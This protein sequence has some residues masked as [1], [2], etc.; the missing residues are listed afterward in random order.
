MNCFEKL[1]TEN[2]DENIRNQ[3][4][5][6]IL[7]SYFFINTT[8]VGKSILGRKIDCFH[9][10][11]SKKIILL[12]GGFHGMEWITSQLL[13]KFIIKTGDTII[14]REKPYI[15]NLSECLK[16][17]S[18]AIIPCVNPD[19]VEI[20]INGSHSARHLQNF[21]ERISKGDTSH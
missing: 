3:F 17:Y 2:C 9:I 11:N 12:C 8:P 16:E 21:V 15:A 19:G 20:A 10:G 4:K 1:L 6:Q 18:L 13:Y 14:N 5:Y 7:Q